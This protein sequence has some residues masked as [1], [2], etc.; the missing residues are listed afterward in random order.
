MLWM[1]KIYT[2][3]ICTWI[4]VMTTGCSVA[5]NEGGNMNSWYDP[6]LAQ[7]VSQIFGKPIDDVAQSDLSQIKSLTISNT[8][9]FSVYVPNSDFPKVEIPNSSVTTLRDLE[10]FPSLETLRVFARS[11]EI[12]GYEFL[13]NI[14][15]LTELD[16]SGSTLSKN[17]LQQLNGIPNLKYLHIPYMEIDYS[18]LSAMDSLKELQ[19]TQA[20]FGEKMSF[21]QLNTLPEAGINI[22]LTG[23]ILRDTDISFIAS[24]PNIVEMTWY[25]EQENLLSI[26][27][28]S[29]I[30]HLYV[31]GIDSLEGIQ[32]LDKLQTLRIHSISRKLNDLSH[33]SGLKMLKNITLST[34]A[35]DK[36]S[37]QPLTNLT[38]LSLL[39]FKLNFFPLLL[40]FSHCQILNG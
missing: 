15:T 14:D 32:S 5:A 34:N 10:K 3:V 8:G 18:E 38:Q 37:L 20:S 17:I 4:L 7:G 16:L 2:L 27:P 24:H 13:S 31:Q 22:R 19:I 9:T 11:N 39:N 28:D 6:I 26:S 36:I 33:L 30:E 29:Q 21:I 25:T 23:I 35:T 12:I 1:R 40:E